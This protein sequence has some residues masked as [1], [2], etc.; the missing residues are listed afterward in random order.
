VIAAMPEV[1]PKEYNSTFQQAQ[2][3]SYSPALTEILKP[4]SEGTVARLVAIPQSNA[5]ARAAFLAVH[6]RAPD[7]EEARQTT[8]FL[9]AH[10]DKSAE[11]VRDLLWAL[12]TSGEFL[13]MP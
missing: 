13:A 1:L 5:R 2:F 7:S 12:M 9:D 11:A 10:P 3:L 6:G 8:D 4:A